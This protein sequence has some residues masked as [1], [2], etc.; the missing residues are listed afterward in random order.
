MKYF[1]IEEMCASDTAR[2][3]GIDNTPN[4]DARLR[5]QTLIEQLPDP[6]RAAWG[7]PITGTCGY[8]HP[9]RNQAVGR[10]PPPTPL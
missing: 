3:K 1:T 5:M 8:R 2:R 7:G 9:A 6:I 4:A 10:G